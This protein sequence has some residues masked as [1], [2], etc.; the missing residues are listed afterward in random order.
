MAPTDALASMESSVMRNEDGRLRAWFGPCC[1]CSGEYQPQSM[2]KGVVKVVVR[3]I[4][5][6]LLPKMGC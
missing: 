3:R 1:L 4:F 5:E 6:K 2:G